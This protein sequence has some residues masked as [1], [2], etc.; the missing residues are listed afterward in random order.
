MF[1]IPKNYFHAALG[2]IFNFCLWPCMDN[3]KQ[4]NPPCMDFHGLKLKIEN[5]IALITLSR[6]ES[7]NALNSDV[8]TSFA[9]AIK[10]LSKNKDLRV[11][12]IT[13]EG[14]AFV[15]GADI[16][17]LSKMKPDMAYTFSRKGQQAFERLERLDIPVIAAINGFTLGGGCELA[18]ACDIRIASRTAKFGMP[19]VSLGLMPGFA[20]TQRLC[21]LIGYSSALYLM[22]TA[23]TINA[24]E[25]LRLG[26]VQKVSE[27]HELMDKAF[28]VAQRI[29]SNG[30]YA[31][32]AVKE[33]ARKSLAASFEDGSELE[34]EV[35]AGL[36]D[37]P[38]A[39]EGLSAFMEKR[40][41]NWY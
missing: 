2:L 41:P 10:E 24:E 21:K 31:V 11:L 6:P 5:Q 1:S 32:K 14:K 26:L 17:E 13:G 15:A 9:N 40:K 29:A 18:L 34:S 25:A 3:V 33:L 30:R 19:E 28:E 37:R 35:F 12:I 16:K 39:N 4:I 22:T 38:E 27:P 36:F 7:L 20:G 23:E 8:L